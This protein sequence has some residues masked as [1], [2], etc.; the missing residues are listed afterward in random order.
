MS[1]NLDIRIYFT[2]KNHLILKCV[3][4]Y[5]DVVNRIQLLTFLKLNRG[6][7]YENG[8]ITVGDNKDVV[9]FYFVFSPQIRHLDKNKSFPK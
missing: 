7:T 3:L 6:W 9:F 5:L 1:D 8:V 4:K 2:L